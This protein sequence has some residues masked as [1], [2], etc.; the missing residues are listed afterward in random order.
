VLVVSTLIAT[1]AQPPSRGPAAAA[2]LVG[3]ATAGIAPATCLI[4]VATAPFG[5]YVG[6]TAATTA[7]FTVT[8]T[9]TTPYTI[10]LNPGLAEGATAGKRWMSN[11]AGRLA[12]SLCSDAAYTL[13]WGQTV[14]VDTVGGTGIGGPQVLTV[15]ARIP[16]GQYPAPGQ[17][18]DTVVATVSY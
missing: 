12:Y 16:P 1:L 9:A 11:S 17:Y 3:A 14:G 8:C 6:K 4:A 7:T 13:N 15:Y 2:T 10:A 5:S 18:S